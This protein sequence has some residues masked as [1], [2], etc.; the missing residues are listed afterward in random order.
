[1]PAPGDHVVDVVVEFSPRAHDDRLDLADVDGEGEGF[2]DVSAHK[3][4]CCQSSRAPS[5]AQMIG[6]GTGARCR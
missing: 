6:T 4:N 5:S 1:V 3:E 2:E